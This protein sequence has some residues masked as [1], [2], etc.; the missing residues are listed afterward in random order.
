MLRRAKRLQSVFN[1]YYLWER[2]IQQLEPAERAEIP[3]QDQQAIV[4]EAVLSSAKSKQTECQ[5]KHWKYK[6]RD[7]SEV[8]LRQ[9]FGR[10]VQ[11]LA[12]FRDIGDAVAVI[13]PI[14]LAIPWAAISCSERFGKLPDGFRGHRDLFRASSALDYATELFLQLV[15]RGTT[16]ICIDAMDEYAD[17][18]RARVLGLIDRL[19]TMAGGGRVK[20]LIS[21]RP[22]LNLTKRFKSSS[23]YSIDAGKNSVDIQAY[24]RAQAAKCLEEMKHRV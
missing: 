13:D 23:C 12:K 19:L 16:T 6:K 5:C 14:H 18:S 10:V 3:L 15:D 7:G 21:S 1:E 4:L 17:E 9:V 11:L 8:E 2:A 20:I 22:S 24:A